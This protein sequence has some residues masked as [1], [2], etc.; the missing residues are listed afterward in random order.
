MPTISDFVGRKRATLVSYVLAAIFIY[1]FASAGAASFMTL[2]VLLFFA[3]LFNF[4]ALSVLAGPVAAEAAPLGMVASVAGL[5]IGAGEVF[6]GGIAPA[7]AGRIA[8]AYGLE[9]VFWFPIASLI[10]GFF[11]ALFL[12]E[13]APRKTGGL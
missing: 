9:N 10:V 13:T 5:V 4:S 6:G 8:G 11:I 12:K 7:I 3:A 2:F 1:L